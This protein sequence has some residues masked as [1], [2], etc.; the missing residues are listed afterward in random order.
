MLFSGYLMDQKGH[1]G[2]TVYGSH[3]WVRAHEAEADALEWRSISSAMAGSNDRR[4]EYNGRGGGYTP[5]VDC[6]VRACL[7]EIDPP[8]T[9]EDG[10]EG[11][12]GWCTPRTH[13][14]SPE[15]RSRCSPA[16]TSGGYRGRLANRPGG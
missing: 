5:W 13:R 7:G 11:A 3:G 2:F 8:I 9:A 14:P 6:T 10:L 1:N 16:L 4:F 12:A 15:L